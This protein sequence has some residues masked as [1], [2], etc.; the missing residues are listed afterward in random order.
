MFVFMFCDFLDP[1]VGGADSFSDRLN[2]KYTV[3]T[4]ILFAIITT[5]QLFVGD[6]FICWCP[7]H[8]EKDHVYYTNGQFVK[9]CI[10]RDC[11]YKVYD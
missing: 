9:M 6:P 10:Y 7:S 3:F 8:Y 11:L 2:C 5:N 4:L 1:R